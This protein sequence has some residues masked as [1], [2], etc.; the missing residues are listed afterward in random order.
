M[1]WILQCAGMYE[2][3]IFAPFFCYI[4]AS[5]WLFINIADDITNDVVAL[6]NAVKTPD[7]G[8]AE[9]MKRFCDIVQFY[10]DA[11]E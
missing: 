2:V 7:T 9:L 6:N 4:F 5:C 3:I 1:A 8:R 10:T 11:K